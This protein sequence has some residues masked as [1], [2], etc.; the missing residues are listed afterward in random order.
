M[1][2]GAVRQHCSALAIAHDRATSEFIMLSRFLPTNIG[3]A[4]RVIRVLL[5]VALIL[6]AVTGPKSPWGY[7]GILPLLTGLFG[8]CPFYS[9]IGMSTCPVTSR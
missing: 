6:L 2:P 9:L 1:P 7:L 3:R 5:G 8:S 4:D